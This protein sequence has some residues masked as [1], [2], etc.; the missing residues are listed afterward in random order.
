MWLYQKIINSQTDISLVQL[1][2]NTR[3]TQNVKKVRDFM[4]DAIFKLAY[5]LNI[6]CALYKHY[7][8]IVVAQSW[9][10]ETCMICVYNK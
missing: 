1:E 4:S 10:L 5:V 7:Q 9:K 6:T 2:E 8:F 3:A